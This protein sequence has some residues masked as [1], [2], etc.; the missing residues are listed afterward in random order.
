[1]IPALAEVELMALAGF[2]VGMLFAYLLEIK[3]RNRW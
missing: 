3:R 2:A 1:M